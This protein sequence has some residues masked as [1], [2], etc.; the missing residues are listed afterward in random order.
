MSAKPAENRG[1]SLARAFIPQSQSEAE[2]LVRS[3]RCPACGQSKGRA[4]WGETVNLGFVL[5][6]EAVK[7]CACG[8]Q[9]RL[10]LVVNEIAR[11][12][13]PGV[14][15]AAEALASTGARGLLEDPD[16]E[17]GMV[18]VDAAIFRKDWT[19][20]LERG[21]SLVFA[22]QND[23]RAWYN[24][25]WLY[26]ERGRWREAAAMYQ[27]ACALDAEFADA[28]HNLSVMFARLGKHHEARLA[29][30]QHRRLR[31]DEAED[32]WKGMEP[33]ATADGL[34]GRVS[35]VQDSR[36]RRMIINGQAQGGAFLDPPA[37]AFEAEAGPGPGAAPESVY[38][39]NWLLAGL[40]HPRGRALM[41]G[42]G[43]GSGAA[44]L[45]A[46]FP[47]LAV[48]AVEADPAVIDLA[49]Q[50]FPLVDVYRRQGRLRIHQTEAAAFLADAGD[51]YQFA[52][53]DLYK[54][55]AR[56]DPVFLDAAFLQRLH[57]R[58]QAIW[59]NL[60]GRLGDGYIRQTL[61]QLARAGAAAR[62]LA[63]SISP[64]SWTGLDANWTVATVPLDGAR[65]AAFS[66]FSR[67]GD[68]DLEAVR[69]IRANLEM[70]W[71]WRLEPAEI[72]IFCRDGTLP[73]RVC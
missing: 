60:I 6:R 9:T 56:I 5:A 7:T 11:V 44:A 17:E 52:A 53:L 69:V 38:T 57:R 42:L 48:D 33:M 24:L 71:K 62:F 40:C 54:G 34:Y 51:D 30:E 37:T 63:A 64:R 10:R 50:Y 29:L 27:R 46:S 43:S 66:P 70:T 35:V 21:E 14:M 39:C 8:F 20:A 41:L 18:G 15:P 58:V 23:A 47:D 55:D 72:D 32:P 36:A 28:W 13:T 16:W 67:L 4:R 49:A 65:M 68:D 73:E 31:P 45:L 1:L 19:S 12:K 3:A 22:R 59:I 2:S 25:G 26:G 61:A